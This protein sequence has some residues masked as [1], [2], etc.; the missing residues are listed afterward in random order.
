MPQRYSFEYEPR[1]RAEALHQPSGTATEL[2][3]PKDVEVG[4]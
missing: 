3:P 1:L 2:R 4:I